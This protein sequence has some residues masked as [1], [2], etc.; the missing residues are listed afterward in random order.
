M[1]IRFKSEVGG[2]TMFEDV[3]VK[4]IRLTGHSGS[5]PGAIAADDLPRSM[6]RL[7]EALA[8]EPKD[9]QAD[10]EDGDGDNASVSMHR[11]AFPLL[12]LMQRAAD[13]GCAVSWEPS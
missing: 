7:R 8:L 11:R 2:F 4:L 10:D 12:D 3:A 5:V 13:E 6:Q 9:P 1:L